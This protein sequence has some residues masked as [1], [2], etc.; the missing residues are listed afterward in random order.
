MPTSCPDSTRWQS[1]LEGAIPET[2]QAELNS[3]LEVCP[4]CQKTLEALAAGDHSWAG[5]ARQ[6]RRG[7]PLRENALGQAI[8][9]LKGNGNP[10]DTLGESVKHGGP[11]LDFLGPAE[12][13]GQLGRLGHYEV[14]EIIGQGGNG[15]VLRALDPTLNRFVAIKVLAPQLATSAAARKRF[16]RE[17]KAAAAVRNEH[18]IGIHEVDEVNG[19]PYLVME[20]INGVSL[21]ERIDRRGPLKLEEILR[22]GMQA[23]TG[24][25]AAHAQGLIHRD[26]K[27]ANIL[28]ENGVE[29][30]KIT[31][32]GLARAVDDASL[33][34]SGVVA[35]T[36]QYMAPEQARGEPL[37]HRADLFSLGS[38]LYFM[39][40][41]RPPFR[42]TETMAVLKR[43]CEDTPR[44]IREINP[45]IP[46]WL[47]AL[48][49]KMQAKNVADRFQT[50]AQVAEQ[51]GQHLA[52]L[53]RPTQAPKP[54]PL[55]SAPPDRQ[56]RLKKNKAGPV[57]VAVLAGVIV[58]V[59][60]LAWRMPT[61]I[62]I[63]S[64]KGT[65][66]V[67]VVDDITP[68]KVLVLRDGRQV[69]L[70]DTNSSTHA[71]LEPGLYHLELIG[72][73][74]RFGPGEIPRDIVLSPRQVT[75]T[76][77]EQAR[78]R[79][80][81][82]DPNVLR[83]GK[84]VPPFEL[85]SSSAQGNA[86]PPPK[87]VKLKA[88]DPATDKLLD[89]DTSVEQGVVRIVKENPIKHEGSV[90][91][92]HV[93][94]FEFP[95]VP[96][97]GDLLYRLK[98]KTEDS[99]G[100]KSSQ[101]KADL[102]LTGIWSGGFE[103]SGA[104]PGKVRA[105]GS[106]DWQEYEFR[107]PLNLFRRG[108]RGGVAVCSLAIHG[109][110][111]VSV[112]DVELYH[113]PPPPRDRARLKADEI[114][115]KS[116]GAADRPIVQDY[117]YSGPDGWRFWTH[118]DETTFQLF[119]VSEPKVEAGR[120]LVFRAKMRTAELL[121]AYLEM[122]CRFADGIVVTSQKP[123]L[124]AKGNTDWANY[125]VAITVP[126]GE[127]PDLIR[128][129]LKLLGAG[130]RGGN[131]GGVP[132]YLN[133]R[134]DRAGWAD[135]WHAGLC[136][137]KDVDLLKASLSSAED[138]KPPTKPPSPSK[139][140]TLKTFDP[141]TDKPLT[142]N[143]KIEEGAWRIDKFRDGNPADIEFFAVREAVPETGLI[144]FRAKI[145]SKLKNES[146]SF[147]GR[148][149]LG[150]TDSKEFGYDSTD[151]Q[152]WF[153][154][155]NSDWV[156]LEARYPAYVFHQADPPVIPANLRLAGVGTLWI[157]DIELVHIP[158]AQ[159]PKIEPPLRKKDEVVVKSFTYKDKPITKDFVNETLDGWRF[160]TSNEHSFRLFELIDPDLEGCR[161]IFRARMRSSL[162]TGAHLE[163]RA[164]FPKE[165][166]EVVTPKP[167][168]IVEGNTNWATYEVELVLPAK[169]RPD[170]LRL[171][172]DILGT[173]VPDTN[174]VWIK[175]MELLKAP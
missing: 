62:G 101:L 93:D 33:T 107:C 161:L 88:F 130:T 43:V 6:L 90:Y 154:R 117:L 105:S 61:L 42:A 122:Q 83:P 29:R 46:D 35:G 103:I 108:D 126:P 76:R 144:L 56:P 65:L 53:Q 113:V 45:E 71:D 52:H 97:V 109:T 3:H 116:L 89:P 156:T 142:E 146:F 15:I 114:L 14:V 8:E 102:E 12:K 96:A 11:L 127:R 150:T 170:L 24:L 20:Y 28:L 136:W 69:T 128:L 91:A 13:P 168:V 120:R 129:N 119:E 27:P 171:N 84:P 164:R 86:A 70:I 85:E 115:I 98:M 67:E 31:D 78:V 39:C 54:A 138:G 80:A 60:M 79:V 94:L 5:T 25:A 174:R 123:A 167:P 111:I 165:P 152:P 172:L 145:K 4:T 132:L 2:E 34:Q 134:G 36:P 173:T 112:K 58:V 74:R 32:F 64:N 155:E 125:D 19:L 18:V 153:W 72:G 21:Q 104:S 143:V 175:D 151:T 57:W 50:A 81:L 121:G 55:E 38:V 160:T 163:I 139:P 41:G 59:V 118:C 159:A 40:T 49:A 133:R 106:T 51:L 92:S 37:D 100:L 77:G 47:C 82:D 169:R 149:M 140:V 63:F 26:I 1:L 73:S 48:I 95:D 66:E 23:A 99:E 158:P 135:D 110:G 87:P 30:V 162:L 17:A 44:P 137:I 22:I 7:Q 124:L 166:T 68:V 147:D 131:V 16:E 75:V 157:K 141:R 148:L 10:S 9:E